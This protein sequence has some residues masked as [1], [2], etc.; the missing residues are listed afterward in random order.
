MHNFFRFQSICILAA[1]FVSCTVAGAHALPGPGGTAAAEDTITQ[2]SVQQVATN[3]A[4]PHVLEPIRISAYALLMNGQYGAALQIFESEEPKNAE[5]Y[6]QI[7]IAA[8]HLYMMGKAK[9]NF[10]KA[11][12]LR[13]RFADAYNNL[14]TLYYSERNYKKAAKYYKESLHIDRRNAC[15]LSNMGT[16]YFSE[17]KY[18]KGIKAYREAF[19]LDKNV[20]ERQA[21]NLMEQE[22]SSK[23][24]AELHF[25]IARIFAQ[26]GMQQQ[27][28]IYL[29][30]AV[31][32]GFNDRTRLLNDS[33]FENVRTEPQFATLLRSMQG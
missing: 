14:G 9:D 15:A 3:A 16:L 6:N 8:E 7:G 30:K 26:S 1:A 20:F 22:L 29:R 19:A 12:K 31:S 2:P 11:L 23:T 5:T 33:A 32:E 24:S 13:P 10:E 18:D 4:A 25:D 28:M 17:K 21:A 27:A